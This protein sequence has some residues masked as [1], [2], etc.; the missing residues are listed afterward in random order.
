[1][2]ASLPVGEVGQKG[3][4]EAG[5]VLEQW[6]NSQIGRVYMDAILKDMKILSIRY[7]LVY[8]K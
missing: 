6:D 8:G 2:S 4:E 7:F 3:A 1:M 5:D